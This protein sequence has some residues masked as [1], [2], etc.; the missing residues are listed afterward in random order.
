MPA[1]N[2]FVKNAAQ[3]KWVAPT[4]APIDHKEAN[5]DIRSDVDHRS[6]AANKTIKGCSFPVIVYVLYA[7]LFPL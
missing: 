1:Q 3:A 2:A 5:R 7:H 4:V 6:D